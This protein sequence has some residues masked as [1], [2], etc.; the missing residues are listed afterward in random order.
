MG[1]AGLGAVRAPRRRAGAGPGGAAPEVKPLREE[2]GLKLT[3]GIHTVSLLRSSLV[4]TVIHCKPCIVFS[5]A[6][7][8]WRLGIRVGGG[9][10]LVRSVPPI[11]ARTPFISGA[12]LLEL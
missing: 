7:C 2:R 10:P 5:R 11:S 8:S 1:A 6:G 9:H 4:T 3:L 12:A